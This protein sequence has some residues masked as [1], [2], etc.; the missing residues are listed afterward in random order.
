M[1]HP[2][3]EVITAT[4]IFTVPMPMIQG[5]TALRQFEGFFDSM[6]TD[7]LGFIGH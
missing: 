3:A 6:V 2:M 4:T 5:M 7:V 1:P